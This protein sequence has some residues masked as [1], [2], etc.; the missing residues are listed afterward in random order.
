MSKSKPNRYCG[1]LFTDEDIAWI[2]RWIEQHPGRGR[3][4][5]SVRFCEHAGW[6]KPDGA[7]KQMSC[8]VALLRMERDGLIKLPPRLNEKNNT[9]L[10]RQWTLWTTAQ[11][12]IGGKAG[13]FS[14]ALEPATKA[15]GPLWNEFVDRYH[16]L[17]YTPLPGAQMRYFVKS[18]GTI[19]ALLSF[20]AAAWKTAPRDTWIGWSAQQRKKNLHLVVNNSRFLILP[21]VQ[22]RYLA[23]KTL[24]MAARQLARDWQER[25]A[26]EPVLIES[27]VEKQRFEGTSYKAA[28]WACVGET[29]GRGKLDVHK[30]YK[31]PKK[32]VWL[33]PLEKDFRKRLVV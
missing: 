2:R 3:S 10:K 16:Y 8:R 18:E 23:S 33:K 9:P 4:E 29:Q 31:L 11:P 13:K 32:S 19:L 7:T 25:Y 6:K 24:G 26:Y 27:F 15:T 30:E 17:G 1:R 22:V 28:G 21:W 12:I 14:L 5:L 20:S